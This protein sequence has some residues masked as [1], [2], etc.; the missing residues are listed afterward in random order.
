MF[1]QAKRAPSA[2]YVDRRAVRDAAG[3]QR[4]VVRQLT[5]VK[6]EREVGGGFVAMG[7]DAS[8]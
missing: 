3:T 8:E 2:D 4:R 6:Y 7:F 1:A 5:A